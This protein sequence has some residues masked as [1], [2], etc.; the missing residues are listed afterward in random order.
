MPTFFDQFFD[1][2]E[3]GT[4]DAFS[5]VFDICPNF[6]QVLLGPDGDDHGGEFAAPRDAN[7]LARAGAF[8]ELGK[9]LFGLEKT[10]CLHK[11]MT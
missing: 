7:L 1:C 11:Y 3:L 9:L 6:V 4:I 2:G 10:N 8:D 5:N